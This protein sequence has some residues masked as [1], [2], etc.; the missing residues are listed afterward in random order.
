MLLSQLRLGIALALLASAPQLAFCQAASSANGTTFYLAGSGDDSKD[1]TSPARA[2]KTIDRVNRAALH[3]GDSILFEGG[4]HFSGNLLIR[5]ASGAPQSP[6]VISSYGN[7][8]ATI[9]AGDSFGIRVENCNFIEVKNLILRGS[10]VDSNGHTTN[11]AQGLDIFSSAKTGQPWRSIHADG[12]DVS[13]FRDG[14]VAHTPIGTQDVVGFDDVR[15]SHCTVHECLL[16]GVYCWGSSKTSGKPWFLPVGSNTFTHFYL[17]DCDVHNIYGDPVG[18]PILCLPTQIFNAT[19]S[20]VERCTI[21]DCGQSANPKGSQGGIGGLVFLECDHCIGQSNECYRMI[22][23]IKFDGCAFDLDGGCSHCILQYNYSHD[24][25]GSGYQHGSF[26]NSGPV[27]DNT[28]RY[29]ISQ[30]D[31]RK[32]PNSSGGIMTWSNVTRGHIYNNTVYISAANGLEPHAFLGMGSGVDVRNN[33]FVASH[34]GDIVVAAPGYQM[35]NNCYWRTDGKFSFTFGGK[36]FDNFADWRAASGQESVDGKPVGFFRDPQ[37]KNAG[38]GKA[39]NAPSMLHALDAYDLVPASELTGKAI[40]LR[41]LVPDAPGARD[42]RD[43]Q[44]KGLGKF[45]LGA[46]NGS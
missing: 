3:P 16:G 42:F 1:G 26:Q 30:N 13:G 39:I 2:L 8:R 25:E 19:D 17:G 14:I 11:T 35:Q 32:N 5:G 36:H 43:V 7:G 41:G 46:A 29:N 37:F 28:I 4:Q 33:I 10:G 18:D 20:M 22:T 12:L 31:A 15:I 27:T 38:G 9:D 34:A 24:N 45:D 40:D 44:L 23:T 21:Y 6:I